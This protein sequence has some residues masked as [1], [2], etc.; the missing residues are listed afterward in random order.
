MGDS[1][2]DDAVRLANIVLD[3][4]YID[5]DGDICML[6]R[7]FLRAVE[8]EG[9]GKWQTIKS[10]PKDGTEVLIGGGF[11]DWDGSYGENVPHTGVTIASWQ[12]S[13][14]RK[15]WRGENV[16]AHDEYYR[17][18]PTHWMPLPK[19]PSPNTGA[20]DSTELRG[21]DTP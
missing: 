12:E 18:D 16:G 10:A 2:F 3:K 21:V 19:P 15:P 8:R 9:V 6:A 5:P 13:Y 14:D 20:D 11:F 1:E 4:P 17:Y 7:Q